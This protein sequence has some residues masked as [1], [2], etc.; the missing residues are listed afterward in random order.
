MP[1]PTPYPSLLTRSLSSAESAVIEFRGIF[2]LCRRRHW[3][4]RSLGPAV[5]QPPPP[6]PSPI[7]LEAASNP[8]PR[9]T[10]PFSSLSSSTNSDVIVGDP[11][12][13]ASI[14][15]R[16]HRRLRSLRRIKYSSLSSN[17]SAVGADSSGLSSPDDAFVAV[18]HYLG[19]Q[20]HHY[21]LRC[22]RRYSRRF[23]V[24]CPSATVSVNIFRVL[25]CIFLCWRLRCQRP[26]LRPVIATPYLPLLSLNPW[27]H[28][29]F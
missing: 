5:E 4:C 19:L 28:H 26:V 6:L 23:I 12:I 14:H 27:E 18:T 1:F 10:P 16:L 29:P 13:P 8:H 11:S 24:S 7:T 2:S 20:S 9:K 15:R 22:Q 17:A 3:C 25:G 21:R